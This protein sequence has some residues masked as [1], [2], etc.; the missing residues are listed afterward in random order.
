ME[1][2][3]IV[4]ALKNRTKLLNQCT[5]VSRFAWRRNR[6]TRI[7]REK[8]HWFES[9]ASCS[10]KMKIELEKHFVSTGKVGD[11]L[12]RHNWKVFDSRYMGNACSK[13]KK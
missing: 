12:D 13:K 10:I 11:L 7:T 4:I 8:V 3:P 9:I 5:L 2:V 6:Q 1:K